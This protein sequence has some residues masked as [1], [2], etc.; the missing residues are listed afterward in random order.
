[1]LGGGA[2]P[3]QVAPE[4]TTGD[5]ASLLIVTGADTVQLPAVSVATAC[6]LYAAGASEPV[7]QVTVPV[8]EAPL[9]GSVA[10]TAPLPHSLML[11]TATLSLLAAV[12]L[13][14]FPVH[15]PFGGE[16]MLTV[17]GVVSPVPVPFDTVTLIDDVAVFPVASVAVKVS[18]W[19]PL[20]VVV[21]F[22]VVEAVVSF[23]NWL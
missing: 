13:M 18:V 11:A 12:M 5:V 21:V 20:G 9:H 8:H 6:T 15:V 17:G 16:V 22:H 4:V 23:T 7:T 1:M 19:V 2:D 14:L 3:P 10:N